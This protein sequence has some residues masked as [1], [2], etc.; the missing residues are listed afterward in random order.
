MRTQN[1]NS[2]GRPALSNQI[3][4]KKLKFTGTFIP[5]EGGE[6]GEIIDN[7][8][9]VKLRGYAPPQNFG[10]PGEYPNGK[11]Y[12]TPSCAGLLAEQFALELQQLKIEIISNR[13]KRRG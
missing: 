4:S 13:M 10:T 7:P 5:T 9:G 1:L 6:A 2:M 8:G 11:G 12:S 3:P